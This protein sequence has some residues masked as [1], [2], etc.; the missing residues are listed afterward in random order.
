[1]PTPFS[2]AS[3]PF[4]TAAAQTSKDETSPFSVVP[5]NRSSASSVPSNTDASTRR[6]PSHS[7][8][9]KLVRATSWLDEALAPVQAPLGSAVDARP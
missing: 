8:T 6:V 1:M 3:L 9:H 2:H 4:K 5:S 7:E